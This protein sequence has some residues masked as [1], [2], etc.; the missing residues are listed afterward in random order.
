MTRTALILGPTGRFGRNMADAFEAAGWNVIRFSR[1]R[2]RLEDA[3]RD[4]EVIVHGW[5]PPYHRW[6]N[7]VPAL[8]NKLIAAARQNDA[9]VIVPGNV[10]PYGADA[11][12][13]LTAET[14]HA[15]RNPLGRI[16]AGMNAA[17]RESGVRT[18]IL[19]AGD[20][21]DTAPSGNWFDRIL[22]SGLRQGRFSYPGPMDRIHTWA[23]LPDMARAAVMLAERA[24]RL[25][26]FTDL[27]FP[28]YGLT[29]TEMHA[30]LERV[31]GRPLQVRRMG[32]L[33]LRAIAMFLPTWRGL[34][35]MRYLW[36]KPHFLDGAAFR[37]VLPEFEP[38]PLETALA[39]AIRHQVNPDETVARRPAHS[40]ERVAV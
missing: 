30:A 3:A 7:E 26:L 27:P 22:A 36:S 2:D 31:A 14:P 17:F 38:T 10:Y 12:E 1:T 18:L 35:E 21:I 9:L 28:G 16:R 32:W 20:F 19:R 29:G 23:Y 40:G 4:A 37:D 6:A 25:D 15:A 34:V 39:S 11:P 5:H 33:P 24:D 13:R 8:T